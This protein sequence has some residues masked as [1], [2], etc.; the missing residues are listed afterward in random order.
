MLCMQAKDLGAEKEEEK[1]KVEVK[2]KVRKEVKARKAQAKAKAK[3]RK[4]KE[5]ALVGLSAESVI[6]KD[7]GEMNAPTDTPCEMS[8]LKNRTKEQRTM[9]TTHRIRISIQDRMLSNLEVSDRRQVDRT[10][11]S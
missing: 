7:I 11:E 1:V 9:D 3:A 4:E 2:E 5:N 6:K 10:Q 8:K